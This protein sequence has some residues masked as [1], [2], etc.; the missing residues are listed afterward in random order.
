MNNELRIRQMVTLQRQGARL[1]L[2]CYK[3]DS[4]IPFSEKGQAPICI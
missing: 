1:P 3:Y 2:A 4:I